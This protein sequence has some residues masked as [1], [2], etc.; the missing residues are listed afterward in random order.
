MDCFLSGEV[1]R[2][3]ASFLAAL[4]DGEGDLEDED[5]HDL[6]ARLRKVLET[7][8]PGEG[9][10]FSVT[11]TTAGSLVS[12]P[13]VPSKSSGERVNFVTATFVFPFLDALRN[14]SLLGTYG[15]CR[16]SGDPSGERA[17]TLSENVRLMPSGGRASCTPG[18]CV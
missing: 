18:R 12:L 13:F 7:E 11:S 5:L 6:L 8:R 2:D 4:G 15:D 17:K 1:L 10:G 9:L 3:L 16:F 14:S